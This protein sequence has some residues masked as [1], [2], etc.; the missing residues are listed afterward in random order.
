MP[1][2]LRHDYRAQKCQGFSFR[3]LSVDVARCWCYCWEVRD[4]L[5]PLGTAPAAGKLSAA[6]A[7]G[8]L[9]GAGS[10][11]RGKQRKRKKEES[12]IRF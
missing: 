2:V 12:V 9:Q 8:A 7:G 1:S 3:V 6:T 10:R 4:V 5:L 11:N